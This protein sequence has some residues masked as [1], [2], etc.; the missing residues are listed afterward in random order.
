MAAKKTTWRGASI[1]KT[2]V[3][4]KEISNWLLLGAGVVIG[5]L[6]TLLISLDVRT[7]T[8]GL[9]AQEAE[10]T[11]SKKNESPNK[12]PVFDFY[13]LLP[14]SEM[15]A[16]V[17]T[18]DEVAA[19]NKLENKSA[20]VELS[21]EHVPV[22]PVVPVKRYLLQA[23]SFRSPEDAASHRAQLLLWGLDAQIERGI[24]K[25]GDTWYRVQL[26][27]FTEQIKISKARKVLE[28]HNIDALMLQLK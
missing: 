13:T 7:M 6:A 2:R 14:K 10:Q 26:G 9:I 15:M 4:K 28:A 22:V 3:G 12:K 27:P 19:S 25:N 20:K 5:V 1:A 18:M 23:G 11:G 17:A 16:P 8:G 24:V 21:V